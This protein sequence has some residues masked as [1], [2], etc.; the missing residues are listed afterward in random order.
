MIQP[1]PDIKSSPYTYH[2]GWNLSLQKGKRG[3]YQKQP[4]TTKHPTQKRKQSMRR[5][6][7]PHFQ[8]AG[9]V[10]A[11][12]VAKIRTMITITDRYKWWQCIT[13]RGLK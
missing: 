4:I 9:A 11:S 6:L 3:L 2:K 12:P 7:L 1:S 10:S 5:N 8:S 13:V